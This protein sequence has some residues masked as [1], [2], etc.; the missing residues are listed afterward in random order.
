[1]SW[2]AIEREIIDILRREELLLT[3]DGGDNVIIDNDGD[4]IFS[5]TE[6]AKELMR[7]GVG[8]GTPR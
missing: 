3:D 1:M 8:Q 5:I 4:V 6:L 2:R 7:R